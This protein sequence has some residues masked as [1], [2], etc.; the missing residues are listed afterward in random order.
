MILD[1]RFYIFIL[2]NA[3]IPLFTPFTKLSNYTRPVIYSFIFILIIYFLL[4]FLKSKKWRCII[5]NIIV[6]FCMIV[7]FIDLFCIVNFNTP[8]SPNIFDTI[9]ATQENE[10][11]NF[12]RFY[13]QIPTNIILIIVYIGIC[14]AFFLI[15]KDF[16][17]TINKK[18][19]GIFLALAIIVL[20]ILAIK[21]YV[22]N[23]INQFHT[24]EKLVQSINITNI[25]YS[26][27]T[28]I[29]QT[30]KYQNYMKNIESNLKNPKTYLL[31]NHATIPNIVII[32]G[33]SASKDFMHIY[34]YDLENTP[35]L[36]KAQA[37]VGGGGYLYLKM[38]SA[39]KPIPNKFS[40]LS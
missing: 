21:D 2:I 12:L 24:L 1:K 17:L 4:D 18:F 35:H 33:E 37:K 23:E 25:F 3:I 27:I 8:I 9:L 39:Q 11:K 10:I 30:K 20:S 26:I 6:L 5:K 28:S 13:L 16:I 14:V 31:Q 7:G 19:V 40:K 32:I 29:V 34:G 38:S 15:K 36:D 22:K